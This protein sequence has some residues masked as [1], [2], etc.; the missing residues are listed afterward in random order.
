MFC[1]ITLFRHLSK[2]ITNC[3]QSISPGCVESEIFEVAGFSDF[4]TKMKEEGRYL[5]SGDIADAV[6]YVLSTPPHVQVIS[7]RCSS[8]NDPDFEYCPLNCFRFMSLL[9]SLLGS[10]YN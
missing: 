7:L 1:E 2:I 4:L 10:T 8:I 3:L 6:V 5:R 9:L